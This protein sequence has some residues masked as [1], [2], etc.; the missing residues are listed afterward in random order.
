MHYL[1]ETRASGFLELQRARVR[2]FL[3]LE[4]NDVPSQ[5]VSDQ[6]MTYRVI[7]VNDQEVELSGAFSEFHTLIYKEI[8]KGNGFRPK[9]VLPSVELVSEIRNAKSIVLKGQCHPFICDIINEKW[10]LSGNK[11]IGRANLQVCEFILLVFFQNF[12]DN[13]TEFFVLI[14]FSYHCV[15]AVFFKF[16]HYW[17]IGVAT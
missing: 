3:S 10:G 13:F 7:K 11:G 9:D 17:I 8:L 16:R 4:R 12:P 6:N 2:W 15:E 14:G 5:P 1:S